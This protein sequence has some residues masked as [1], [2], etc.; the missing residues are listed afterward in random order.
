M[1]SEACRVGRRFSERN[2]VGLLFIQWGMALKQNVFETYLRY[3]GNLPFQW[4]SR[5]LEEVT[6]SGFFCINKGFC[7]LGF[8]KASFFPVF[9]LDP[10]ILISSIIWERQA[11]DNPL[12][13][14]SASRKSYPRLINSWG[15]SPPWSIPSH[16][17]LR[18]A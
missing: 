13:A 9:C 11:A 14:L 7:V 6:P 4:S 3:G 12:E 1:S 15:T 10:K 2:A 5:S 8:F 17:P 16:T 18:Q